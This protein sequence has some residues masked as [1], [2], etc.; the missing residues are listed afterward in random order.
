MTGMCCDC[1]CNVSVFSRLLC[2][3]SPV[4]T[5]KIFL[6][7]F[8]SAQE[9]LHEK[10]SKKISSI[11]TCTEK[12][13]AELENVNKFLPRFLSVS[14]FNKKLHKLSFFSFFILFLL[15]RVWFFALLLVLFSSRKLF[16]TF[17][18]AIQTNWKLKHEWRQLRRLC[19]EC[20]TNRVFRSLALRRNTKLHVRMSSAWRTPRETVGAFF[21]CMIS[22]ELCNLFLSRQATWICFLRTLCWWNTTQ[23]GAQHHVV[24][25]LFYLNVLQTSLKSQLPNSGWKFC[26]FFHPF[27]ILSKHEKSFLPKRE[28]QWQII[29][30]AF[31]ATCHKKSFHHFINSRTP[32]NANDRQMEGKNTIATSTPETGSNSIFFL[33]S[34]I[35]LSVHL[36]CKKKHNKIFLALKIMSDVCVIISGLLSFVRSLSFAALSSQPLLFIIPHRGTAF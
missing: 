36:M 17:N 24:V 3:F 34:K 26:K 35:F 33:V 9:E 5:G 22:L 27:L 13:F 14:N 23:H 16:L 31:D 25:S 12:L 8:I 19:V 20:C 4:S 1:I 15:N 7:L 29:H 28:N 21:V 30:K 32:T 2:D 6:I 11:K 18:W 10:I